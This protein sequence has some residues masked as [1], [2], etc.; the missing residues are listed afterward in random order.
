VVFL[1]D[2]TYLQAQANPP[3]AQTSV[4]DRP[5]GIEEGTYSWNPATGTIEV[6]PV[7][8]TNNEGGLS[9]LTPNAKFVLSPDQSTLTVQDKG[10]TT[11]AA[12]ITEVRLVA[13][14]NANG[15][16]LAWPDHLTNY[17]VQAA[18]DPAASQWTTLA[19]T[20]FAE[21]GLLKLQL[22]ASNRVTLFRLFKP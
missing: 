13:S 21:G 10:Q 16:V 12:K 9:G 15:I 2:G 6:H 22:Q 7:I 1:P 20:P 17:T 14:A 4:A 11:T 19:E 8:D 5:N 3:G 18:T